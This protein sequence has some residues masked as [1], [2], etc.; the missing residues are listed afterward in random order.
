MQKNPHKQV[1]QS[2][3]I[4]KWAKNLNKCFSKERKQM[5]KRHENM[6][7]V[8]NHQKN[9]N[10]KHNEILVHTCQNGYNQKSMNKW[11]LVRMQRKETSRAP[12]AE[13]QTGAATLENNIKIPQNTKNRAATW[14][15]NCTSGYLSKGSNNNAHWKRCMHSYVPR[16]AI[17]RSQDVEAMQAPTDSWRCGTC[18]QQNVSDKNMRSC[19]WWT[20]D[21][22]R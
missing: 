2:N 14:P 3:S 6:P 19:H 12:L 13:L 17:Y 11:V 16:S 1:K 10:Q 9:A 22:S 21:A 7:S 20:W 4:K 15:C 5:A 18:I 8:T